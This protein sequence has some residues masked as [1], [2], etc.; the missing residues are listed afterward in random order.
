MSSSTMATDMTT[1]M[2]MIVLMPAPNSMASRSSTRITLTTLAALTWRKNSL[3]L[4]IV[5]AARAQSDGSFRWL[6]P[7]INYPALKI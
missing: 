6:K 7:T 5:A 3:S 1:S 2:S 4:L